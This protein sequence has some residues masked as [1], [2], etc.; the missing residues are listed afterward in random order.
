MTGDNQGLD[1]SVTVPASEWG[2]LKRRVAYLEAALIQ[3][4]R[5][6]EGI[7]EWF[8]TADLQALR[9]PDIPTSK[10]AITRLAR[11]QGWLMREVECQGG[12]RHVY[13]FSSL[14]RRAFQELLDRVL[15]RPPNGSELVG[16]QDDQV[17]QVTTKRRRSKAVSP[18]ICATNAAPAWVLP[19]MRIIRA[20]GGNVS[21]ALDEL[22][23]V[24]PAGV[25]CP[26]REEALEVLSRLGLVKVS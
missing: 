2:M 7:K 9:L 25:A 4:M 19:L 11:E 22:P 21:Q 18:P 8:G 5:E 12:T 20:E 14:P 1:L 6:G 23:G 24:L 17:D 10:N 15:Q 16:N 3:V 13:H 26:S